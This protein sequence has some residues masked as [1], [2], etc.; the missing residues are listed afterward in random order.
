LRD[1]VLRRC[2]PSSDDCEDNVR[3]KA[4]FGLFGHHEG[5]ISLLVDRESIS[6]LLHVFIKPA[7]GCMAL[8]ETIMVLEP[9]FLISDTNGELCCL[10]A[11]VE[12]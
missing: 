8:S 9:A 4:L 7:V 5:G 3:D 2:L 1:N 11:M 12:V 10:S 6:C